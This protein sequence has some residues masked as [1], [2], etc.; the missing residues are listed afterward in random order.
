MWSKDCMH[1][2]CRPGRER[3]PM[4]AV[5][6]VQ[7][8]CM[9]RLWISASLAVVGA[10]GCSKH[11]PAPRQP[12]PPVAAEPAPA[13]AP[14][15]PPAP[16]PHVSASEELMRACVQ[17][18]GHMDTAPTFAF[19]DFQLDGTDRDLLSQIAT[20]VT[21]GPLK[22]RTLALTGHADPRGTDE[23]NLGLG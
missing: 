7:E 14:T 2:P 1:R 18:L 11:Q 12:A 4:R 20:C 8:V 15:I 9:R 5:D 13:P 16:A 21:T 6:V 19:D 23:Y 22:G 10:A 17:R 3:S